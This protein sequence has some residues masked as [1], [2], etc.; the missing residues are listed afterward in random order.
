MN[1]KFLTGVGIALV[2]A[3]CAST[4]KPNEALESARSTVQAAQADPNA[5]RYAAVNLQAAKSDLA[6]ADAAFIRRDEPGIAQPAYMAAQNA[7]L[8][9]LRGAAKADDARVA[10]GQAERDKIILAARTNQVDSANRAKDAANRATDDA[11]ISRDQATENAA[12]LQAEV[13]ALK[14]KPTDR[15]LVLTLGDVLFE[16]GS[17]TLSSGAARNMDRLVQFLTDHPERLVQIDGFTDSIGTDSFNEDLSQRRA[18]AVRYQLVSRGIVSTRIATQ[19]YG[20]AYPVAS[21]SESSGRQLNRRVEV[22]IG[23]DNGT[24]VAGRRT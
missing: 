21:N 9:Q 20:K 10:A 13:D 3:G 24:A 5:A 17:S 4:P 7:R 12:R 22:V 11:K 23:S 14:A 2:I 16:T 8:A 19:G 15:G 1:T 18:D 6:V